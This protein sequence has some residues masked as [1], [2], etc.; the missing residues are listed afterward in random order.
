[1]VHTID[2]AIKAVCVP[3]Q[4]VP[5]GIEIRSHLLKDA[6]KESRKAKFKPAIPLMVRIVMFKA[7][8]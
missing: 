8:V 7:S 4:G 3:V 5:V 2:E 1:M 6:L